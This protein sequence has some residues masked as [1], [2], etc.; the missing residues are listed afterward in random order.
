[1]LRVTPSGRLPVLK[2]GSNVFI[3][4]EAIIKYLEMNNP[5]LTKYSLPKMKKYQSHISHCTKTLDV[6]MK[7]L[8]SC[9]NKTSLVFLTEQFYGA[10]Q[11][12]DINIKGPY[13]MGGSFTWV[14][15]H[16][17]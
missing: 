7:R 9:E 8:I 10:L 6:L 2:S 3:G 17:N 16:N 11:E 13:F 5:K 1:M 15:C 4:S 12:M 14:C